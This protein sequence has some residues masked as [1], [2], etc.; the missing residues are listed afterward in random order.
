MGD[1]SEP[2]NGLAPRTR[3]VRARWLRAD[4]AAAGR[5]GD[6][7]ACAT[8]GRAGSAVLIPALAASQ[9]AL[10]LAAVHAGEPPRVTVAEEALVA[11]PRDFDMPLALLAVDL[12]VGRAALDAL[13]DGGA[14]ATIAFIGYGPRVALAH[15]EVAARAPETRSLVFDQAPLRRKVAAA[16]GAEARAPRPGAG[17]VRAGVVVHDSREDPLEHDEGVTSIDL[18]RRPSPSRPQVE[19]AVAAIAAA[20]WRYRPVLTA[21]T[22]P[23]LQNED[24]PDPAAEIAVV[25]LL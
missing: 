18:G 6:V 2:P 10:A 25:A 16:L 1:R 11:L 3:R 22:A 24:R 4:P 20:P 5:R 21:A 19:A 12:A 13:L 9:V 17:V 23:A 7:P 14:P 8:F 15:A